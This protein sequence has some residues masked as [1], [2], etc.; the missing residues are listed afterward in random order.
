M[1]R[2]KRVKTKYLGVYYVTGRSKVKYGKPERIYYIRYRRDGREFEK[3]VGRQF[4]DAMTPAKAAKFR[5]ELLSSKSEFRRKSYEKIKAKKQSDDNIPIVELKKELAK[6]KS[7]EEKWLLFMQSSNEAF[8]LLDSKLRLVEMND[9][10]LKML[11]KKAK[12]EDILGKSLEEFVPD[13]RTL[14]EYDGII[15]VLKTG[16]PFTIT[17]KVPSSIFGRTEHYSYKVF[18]VG[19]GLGV[20][21]SDITAFKEKEIELRKREKDLEEINIALRVLLKK[22][23]EDR[24]ELE[25]RMLF[26]IKELVDPYLDKIIKREMDRTQKAYLEIL[27]TNL[28]DIVS[29]LVLKLSSE[30]LN[31]TH[32]EIQI[33]NLIKIGKSSKEIAELLSLSTRTIESYRGNIRK[34]LAIKNKKVNLRTYL[35]SLP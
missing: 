27:Q 25:K 2:R 7:V 16:E 34:K 13:L 6:R 10:T 12:K 32:M 19:D 23:E 28:E 17:V 3:K 26:N 5:A 21:G 20:I 31:L 15:K 29:P 35:L 18:K 14:P 11:S 9:A 1:P 24:T 33:A 30:Y 4:Q 22:R 8:S